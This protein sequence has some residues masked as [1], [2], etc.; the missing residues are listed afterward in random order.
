M[1]WKR[2]SQTKTDRT[3]AGRLARVFNDIG[4]SDERH[5]RIE[6]GKEAELVMVFT[7]EIT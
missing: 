6:A 7:C 2:V 4:R 1:K 5:L 3:T